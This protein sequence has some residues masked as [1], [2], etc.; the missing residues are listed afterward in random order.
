MIEQLNSNINILNEE[1]QSSL[2]NI[3]KYSNPKDMKYLVNRDREIKKLVKTY[4][5]KEN[6]KVLAWISMEQ[7]QQ[8]LLESWQ[9]LWPYWPNGDWVDGDFWINTFVWIINIQKILGYKPTW[10]LTKELIKEIFS[11]TDLVDK[12][13]L[14][15]EKV[16]KPKQKIIQKARSEWESSYIFW[17]VQFWGDIVD[18]N[19]RDYNKSIDNVV[20]LEENDDWRIISK[21]YDEEIGNWTISQLNENKIKLLFADIK[22]YPFERNPETKVTQCAKTNRLNFNDL[23]GIKIPWQ[24]SVSLQNIINKWWI[25]QYKKWN[26][27]WFNI[28]TNIIDWNEFSSIKEWQVIQVLAGSNSNPQYGHTFPV[29]KKDWQLYAI[30]PYS[31]NKNRKPFLLSEH[32]KF[33]LIIKGVVYDTNVEIV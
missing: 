17:W 19:F 15:N 21:F 27:E 31:N 11:E 14:Y 30:D 26:K 29:F 12:A 4:F 33:N 28:P 2:D 20:W 22:S 1:Q 25:E 23:F 7:L 24:T 9:K 13:D 18:N 3:L 8:K 6:E 10:I 32:P 5:K 16:T